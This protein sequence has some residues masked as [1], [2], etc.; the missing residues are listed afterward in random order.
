MWFKST[1]SFYVAFLSTLQ[2]RKIVQQDLVIFKNEK[3][4][5][6]IKYQNIIDLKKP[7]TYNVCPKRKEK[8]IRVNF[9][10]LTHW[11][12]TKTKNQIL[13]YFGEYMKTF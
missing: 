8:E 3:K 7:I 6:N 4:E 2:T 9:Y 13:L 1:L 12:L 10:P 5:K 11:I